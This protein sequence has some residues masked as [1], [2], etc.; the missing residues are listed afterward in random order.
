M[1]LS[2][3]AT[4]YPVTWRTNHF[5]A[6]TSLPDVP[7]CTD[8]SP[9]DQC[10]TM[11]G[12]PAGDVVGQDLWYAYVTTQDGELEISMCQT[13]T[14]WDSM[15]ALY[16]GPDGADPGDGSTCPCPT[17]VA[18]CE[19]AAFKGDDGA[20]ASDERCT[21][22]PVG[23]AGIT[24]RLI[25]ANTCVV[26][27]I[28]AWGPTSST[29]GLGFVSL[30]LRPIEPSFT[31][32]PGPNPW[33]P[34]P[35]GGRLNR[36]G[37]FKTPMPAT[38]VGEEVAIRVKVVDMYVDASEDPS[39]CP[40]RVGP[41]DVGM[42]DGQVQYLGPPAAFD[43]NDIT[44]TP[45]FVASELQDTPYYRDWSPSALAADLGAGVDTDAVYFYGNKVVPCSVY[46]VTQGTQACVESASED[47]LSVPLEIH[48]AL[49]G[50]VWVPFGTVNFTD[51]GQVVDAWN[52]I[53]FIP[54]YPPTGAPKK[55]RAMLR[56]NSAPLSTKL[57]FTDIG[58]AVDAWK[59]I[60]FKDVPTCQ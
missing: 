23:G 29:P 48:T 53:P 24:T 2:S 20:M 39:G 18:S 47:C 3:N 9:P 17:D 11:C 51:I 38:A 4:A 52:S 42:C 44:V 21:N 59:T 25:A 45:K 28:G 37:S 46:D 32:L 13:G 7:V 8:F 49:W 40:V 16:K 41:P 15:F 58:Q 19:A 12:D 31:L 10:G 56:G 54:G 5:C 22:V 36:A 35:K 14:V 50:D 34:D 43:D 27:Q 55:V 30:G 57:N 1:P 60:A 6:T 33:D 26:L